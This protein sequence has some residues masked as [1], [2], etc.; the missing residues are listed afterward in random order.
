MEQSM[1]FQ[2]RLFVAMVSVT[3]FSLMPAGLRA[4]TPDSEYNFNVQSLVDGTSYGVYG[5]GSIINGD[6]VP[7][8]SMDCVAA[9]GY[10]QWTL[11]SHAGTHS[12]F[13]SGWYLLENALRKPSSGYNSDTSQHEPGCIPPGVVQYGALAGSIYPKEPKGAANL[14]TWINYMWPDSTDRSKFIVQFFDS[15]DIDLS[16]KFCTN[17][18][19]GKMNVVTASAIHSDSI[20]TMD[21][22]GHVHNIDTE[23]DYRDEFDDVSDARF[24]YYVWASNVNPVNPGM[25]EIW[26]MVTP[27]GSSTPTIMPFFVGD[28]KFPTVSCDARNNRSGTTPKFD[29][30]Y[31][32]PSGQP[33]DIS[34][35][36]STP[37][38]F[39]LNP[40][41]IPP[42]GYFTCDPPLGFPP[43]PP[44]TITSVTHVRAIVSE[45]AGQTTVYHGLYLIGYT[46]P[47][48]TAAETWPNPSTTEGLF[49]YPH[50]DTGISTSPNLCDG[51]PLPGPSSTVLG[52]SPGLIASIV[53][54]VDEP[55]TAICDPYDN[56]NRPGY[57]GFHVV[58]RINALDMTDT[59]R[60]PL[61]IMK[62]WY[63]GS[64]YPDTTPEDSRLMLTTLVE[65][66]D[67]FGPVAVW[68]PPVNHGYVAAV[69][70]MGIH[71]HWRTGTLGTGTHY[72][73][74]DMKR[75]FNEPIEENTIVTDLCMVTDGSAT[76][77]NH[78]G[79]VGAELLPGKKMLIYTDPNYA[80]NAASTNS[81]LYQPAD[82]NV[83]WQDI[84]TLPYPPV[85]TL[86]LKGA[87]IHDSL[88]T[89]VKLS[90]GDPDSANQGATLTVM[91]NFYIL[92]PPFSQANGQ[93]V[94]V[95]GGDTLNYYGLWG[96]RSSY[97]IPVFGG[98]PQ[99]WN[100]LSF[101]AAQSATQYQ[102]EKDGEGLIDLEGTS[103][104]NLA[105]LI[106]HG[107]ANFQIGEDAYFNSTFG[108]IQIKNEDNIFPLL[109]SGSNP[110]ASGIMTLE[111]QATIDS[112]KVTAYTGAYNF[113]IPQPSYYAVIHAPAS[114][115]GDP[116]G[117]GIPGPSNAYARTH[118]L[119]SFHT[120]YTDLDSNGL[121]DNQALAVILFDQSPLSDT[122]GVKDGYQIGF[123]GPYYP[124]PDGDVSFSDDTF[125]NVEITAIDPQ[126]TDPTP[127]TN[128][129]V[130]NSAFNGIPVQSI[131]IEHTDFR[132]VLPWWG[133][134]NISGNTFNGYA[135]PDREEAEGYFVY[136]LDLEASM[137]NTDSLFKLNVENNV[138]SAA[139]PGVLADILFTASDGLISSNTIHN[140]AYAGINISGIFHNGYYDLT[141]IGCQNVITGSNIG[142]GIQSSN[143]QG[144]IKLD[145][146]NGVGDGWY[147][148][149]SNLS[150]PHLVGTQILGC[151]SNGILVAST[152]DLS[153]VHHNDSLPESNDIPGYNQI[154]DNA[155]AQIA[156]TTATGTPNVWVTQNDHTP[157][158]AWIE[159]G[160]NNIYQGSGSP[161]LIQ[162]ISF[163]NTSVVIDSNYWGSGI[164]PPG[165][166]PSS[167]HW[168]N[169]NFTA[170]YGAISFTSIPSELT[171]SSDL[172]MV[173]KSNRIKPLSTLDA[174]SCGDAFS[175]AYN[176]DQNTT[177][178]GGAYDTMKW[179]ITHCYQIANA[180][181][182]WGTFGD[183]FD[184]VGQTAPGRQAAFNFILYALGLRSDDDWFCE[185]VP[186][187]AIGYDS[188][189]FGQTPNYRADR[190]LYLYL[191]DNPRCAGNYINDSSEY[192]VL[193]ATQYQ[194]WTDSSAP[195][196]SF[197]S[198]V[199][200]LQ[201]LGLDTLLAINAKAGVIFA[202]P[203]PPIINSA[204]VTENP[205]ENSTSVAL[206]I[207]REAYV[208][209]G[210]YNVLGQQVPGAGYAG[211]FE[212]GSRTIPLD[213]TSAPS[214][215]YYVR[216][217]TA[218]SEV[219]TLKLTKE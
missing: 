24:H 1:G 163:S 52:A 74:R 39:L 29:V 156:I 210:V 6:P 204:S 182:T 54:V 59:V 51:P 150:I 119:N 212:Q 105:N 67:S 192:G 185:G 118:A 108:N 194:I 197:D 148:W 128:F 211:V 10:G 208:T 106:I 218:G 50:L 94:V 31:I 65:A 213:M 216:I 209:I 219:Q 206:S 56:Q 47:G 79:T 155:G 63:N 168:P 44:P 117:Y 175:A 174:D 80:A 7:I 93:S 103:S 136:G 32:N 86:E 147:N 14:D 15:S 198:S 123:T 45:I 48:N 3:L 153:G 131:D 101:G 53:G 16:A 91:P 196:S 135:N 164:T 81:G 121:A 57:E 9:N 113:L 124:Y 152:V 214:G 12:Q 115:Q 107:G 13:P 68:P 187:L 62:A 126:N 88:E 158:S 55:I 130:T 19:V 137:D 21:D 96:R 146:I 114:Y 111:G 116:E 75:T 110:S 162:G 207:G 84:A 138:F 112:S 125:N 141:F 102:G 72:Y 169:F 144:Y 183:S 33:V 160:Q 190:A 217:S 203:T 66:F 139:F 191:M 159:A 184:S 25:K 58:Y 132:D 27:L 104:S 43:C 193:L 205:F 34:Y 78:G 179:Y 4:Q 40:E 99:Y 149:V 181:E 167:T 46:N 201:D 180:G 122:N 2:K 100:N 172:D 98:V 11:S 92:F 83:W 76:G 69:N 165:S 38:P 161:Y 140:T 143:Y 37:K 188:G 73:A 202:L 8:L 87:S 189:P 64:T 157:R 97:S 215:A 170:P 199:P 89:N 28:G 154:H 77:A 41:F 61:I 177:N 151:S 22:S 186:F 129:N 20:S 109:D 134:I 90:I 195:G 42:Y 5:G 17:P 200:S 145:S 173:K 171:C 142:Y 35:T 176:W 127:M 23:S 133:N 71:V 85:G 70:Q 178:P 26:A 120:T 60:E 18:T 36:N 95:Y 30:A 49:L 166:S 82:P